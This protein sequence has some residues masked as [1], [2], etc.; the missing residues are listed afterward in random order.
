M[1]A[2]LAGKTACCW[3]LFAVDLGVL[4]SLSF[5]E[6]SWFWRV[7]IWLLTNDTSPDNLFFNFDYVSFI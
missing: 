1:L 3:V 4:L 2:E 6:G 5:W 7:G